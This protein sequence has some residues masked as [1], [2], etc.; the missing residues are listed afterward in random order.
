MS[1]AVLR[2]RAISEVLEDGSINYICL[3]IDLESD[4]WIN[5]FIEECGGID[6]IVKMYPYQKL[7]IDEETGTL[8]PVDKTCKY[9]AKVTNF[10]HLVYNKRMIEKQQKVLDAKR[11]YYAEHPIQQPKQEGY[12]QVQTAAYNDNIVKQ[13][14][15]P[16]EKL[17]SSQMFN[18]S[19]DD[20]QNGSYCLNPE[21][22]VMKDEND[23]ILLFDDYGN[24]ISFNDVKRGSYHPNMVNG[25]F[26]KANG[27]IEGEELQN[28]NP[29]LTMNNPNYN[30]YYQQPIPNMYPNNIGTGSF[31]PNPGIGWY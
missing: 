19:S 2:E 5:D 25:K 14:T 7:M 1:N 16:E 15:N 13:D 30:N 11:K 27:E 23:G 17:E 24:S 26:I 28:I 10:F 4:P 21:D 9:N 6:E 18:F 12:N 29:A 8:V 20:L 22:L 3:D 31:I